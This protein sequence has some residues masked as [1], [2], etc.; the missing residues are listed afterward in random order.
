MYIRL[1][2]K[3]LAFRG[4]LGC[5]AG[6]AAILLTQPNAGQAQPTPVVSVAIT[7][8]TNGEVFAGPANIPI[9][10]SITD[11]SGNVAYV[12]FTA[13]PLSPILPIV[14]ELGTS[15]NFVSLDATHKLCEFV[16]TNPPVGSQWSLQ[17]AAFNKDG[18][19]AGSA[20]VSITISSNVWFSVD[21][22]SPTNG[23]TFDGPTNI[24]LVAN[25]FLTNDMVFEVEFFDG[26]LLLGKGSVMDA[27][28]A[29]HTYIF[30]WT[31]QT[32]GSHVI[33]AL[34]TD[35]NGDTVWS[36]AV[37][38]TVET[39][40][41]PPMVLITQ[42][43]NQSTFFAPTN[44]QFVV[45]VDDPANDVGS[46]SFTATP[47]GSGIIE[48]IVL[49][50]GSVTNWTSLDP[51]TRL[52]MFNWSNAIIG[53]WTVR[54]TAFLNDG[55]E[56]GSD[57]V[58]ITVQKNY[59][60]SV[61][62]ASPT[63]ASVFPGPTNISLIAGVEETNDGGVVVEFFDGLKPLGVTSNWAV[64]DPPGGPGLPP[65]SHAY[66][67]DWT[68]Q[69][70]GTHVITA[71]A[72]DTNGDT[73]WS[74]PVTIIVGSLSN[75]PPIVRISS[76][77]NMSDFRAPV[78]L[79]LL[80]FAN[81]PAGLPL[82][83]EFFA[84]T[85]AL[86]FGQGLAINP[87]GP[88]IPYP[89]TNPPPAVLFT[90]TFVLIWTNPPPGAYVL[91]AVATDN[92]GGSSTSSPVNITIE[93][94]VPPPTNLT[95]VVSIVAT[96][97]IAIAGTNCWPWL[98]G[99][100][101]WSNWVSPT[102][103]MHWYTN[104]GPVD[105]AF[106]VFRGGSTNSDLTLDYTIGGTATNGVDY[107]T[108]PGSVTIPAGHTVATISVVPVLNAVSNM[109][110]TVI[111]TL[112]EP[113]NGAPD[114]T[115]GFPRSAEAI[116]IGTNIAPQLA[117]GGS[118]LPDRSFHVSL[119]GPDGGWFHIDYTSNLVYWTPVCTNQVINGAID[120]VDPGAAT[121]PVRMYR[122]VPLANPPSD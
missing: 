42:P 64:V 55:E 61:D 109:N 4:W 74:A 107:V 96:D 82:V 37:T 20:P 72:T 53:T 76:P 44:V 70:L 95:A 40:T 105:G 19:Q 9:D 68:N 100:L 104:C 84:G 86:G 112:E 122:V 80:A 21:I 87:G 56:A 75:F 101:T 79:P 88:I 111:L 113:T 59:S 43:T 110:S 77:P 71:S 6:A 99:P 38:I 28:P 27:S 60:L 116:I 93:P 49:Y 8:P 47:A 120:F 46:L 119:T 90:N 36:E 48:P 98:G 118:V 22:T 66:F 34:A 114:Y 3:S 103:A 30:D 51:P 39:E 89:A 31:N 57:N 115:L 13:A 11:T 73:V 10:A 24:D 54:A 62:I 52:Y 45:S 14:L 81:D 25:V 97:P 78:N 16:W 106:T 18:T 33:T 63:N 29:G 94:A 102:A 2:L 85:N 7:Q 5:M 83:V 26:F 92:V 117:T 15:S 32:L 108:L 1:A 58:T 69:T 35:T 91:T 65:A 50:L 12:A 23:A 121:A 41:N 17:A 67:F